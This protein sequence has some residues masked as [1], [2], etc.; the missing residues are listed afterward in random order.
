MPED[1][2][3]FEAALTEYLKSSK[4]DKDL[5]RSY[6][7]TIVKLKNSGFLLERIWKYGQPPIIDGI[8]VRCRIGINDAAKL[9]EIARG[10]RFRWG[11]IFPIGIPF[12]EFLEVRARFGQEVEQFETFR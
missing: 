1:I 2:K 10:E 7:A 11:D 12:P 6:T 8:I 5:V 4:L 3:K 9:G